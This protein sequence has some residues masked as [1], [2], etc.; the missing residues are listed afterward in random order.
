MSSSKDN[1]FHAE[2]SVIA[3]SEQ[4]IQQL[5]EKSP[6]DPSL[7]GMEM[8]LKSH[9]RL[10]KQTKRLIKVGDR[11]QAQLNQMKKR[12]EKENS[13]LT[14][15]LGI[16]FESFV[17]TLAT[18]IDAKHPLT[19]GHSDRITEYTLFLGARMGATDEELEVIKYACLLHDMG[20]IA[21]PD[22]VLTKHGRFDRQERQIMNEHVVWTRRILEQ[23]H[24][25]DHLQEIPGMAAG[26]HERMDGSGYPLGLKG[27]DIPLVARIMAVADVFDALTS[28]RDYPKYD[29]G[30]TFDT[31]PFPFDRVFLLLEREAGTHFDPDIVH[32]ALSNRTQME[33][34]CVQLHAS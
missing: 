21:T 15:E 13:N 4:L 18:I 28:K 3:Q 8:L 10:L 11:Q 30:E 22:A 2:E 19:A 7:P 25:P 5:S 34:L 1:L 9:K 31:A 14:L 26:H 20:K 29:G 24:L 32:I 17:R 12:L 16:A 6:D 33:R 27:G 23:M